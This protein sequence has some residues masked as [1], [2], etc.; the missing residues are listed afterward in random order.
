[1]AKAY[2]IVPALSASAVRPA[3]VAPAPAPAAAGGGPI[4]QVKQ[5]VGRL[6]T[7]MQA[8]QDE[9]LLEFLDAKEAAAFRPIFEAAKE[10]PPKAKQFEQLV[11]TKLGM[12]LP[13]D[14]KANLAGKPQAGPAGPADLGKYSLDDFKFKQE[15]EA[16]VVSPPDGDELRFEKVGQ[17]WKIKLGPAELEAMSLVT[18]LVKAQGKVL[19]EMTAG[20]DSG[21]ITK[22]N[23]Q[24]LSSKHIMP[25][26]GKLMQVM[27]KAMQEGMG[28]PI[29]GVAPGPTSAPIPTLTPTPAP[30]PDSEEPSI[31]F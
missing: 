29:P 13:Q 26:F 24:E 22:A 1:M 28:Q 27:M 15:G 16:I 7:A 9:R 31:S 5:T 20:I 14:M 30:A 25:A 10:L 23:F 4:E 11:Q 18:D 3:P 2:G 19:D 17:D 12:T 6:I 8:G 21:A